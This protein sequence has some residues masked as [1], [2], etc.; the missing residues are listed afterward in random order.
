MTNLQIFSQIVMGIKPSIQKDFPFRSEILAILDHTLLSI[1]PQKCVEDCITVENNK[2][3]FKNVMVDTNTVNRIHVIGFGKAVFPMGMGVLQKIDAGMQQGVVI[4][5][6]DPEIE[7][8]HLRENFKTLKGSHPVPSELS[9][10]S[11]RLLIQSLINST[12]KDLVLCLI[13][14][15]GSSIFTIPPDNIS[16]L[17]LQE[18]TLLLLEC[19]ASIDEINTIRKHLDVVKGGGLLHYIHPSKSISLILSD[20]ISDDISMIASGPTTADM[21]TFED[22]KNVILK[23]HLEPKVHQSIMKYIEEGVKKKIPE[24]VKQGDKLLSKHHNIIIGNLRK[25][26]DA[27]IDMAQVKGFKTELLSLQYHGE[28]RDVGRNLG[29]LLKETIKNR[30]DETPLC[31]IA[32]GEPTVTIRGSGKGGRNQEVA[33]SAAIEIAGLDDCCL[34]T[35]ATD[36]EDG[37]TDAA[38]AIVDGDT[39]NV[40]KELGLNA[41]CFLKNNDSYNYLEKTKSLLRTGP[42]HTNVNDL[43][44]ILVS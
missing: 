26:A 12:E 43:Y 33:L 34:I 11:S 15:G 6:H 35:L 19:G 20:V 13:S 2:I 4:S 28:A 42:T 36:G 18:L 7:F 5:K 29:S 16:L 17:H 8:L 39:V 9:V 23:Y 40:G 44:I 22:A 38:G 27:A 41:E 24:T 14:G 10:Q 25:A 32:G 1:N 31:L 37:P 30:K 3:W 21:T